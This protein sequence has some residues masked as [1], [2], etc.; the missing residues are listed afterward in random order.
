MSSANRAA[1]SEPAFGVRCVFGTYRAKVE[2]DLIVRQQYAFPILFRCRSGAS[3]RP[4]AADNCRVWSGDRRGAAQHVPHRR[5]DEG[6]DRRGIPC[7]GLRYRKGHA[8]RRSTTAIFRRFIRPATFRW[9]PKS[10]GRSLPPFAELVIG[11][12]KETVGAY[13]AALSGEAPIGFVAV[14]VDY[15]S[16]T[17]SA[18]QLLTGPPEL[19]LPIVPVYLDDIASY[20]CSDWT[21]E[22]LA[23]NEFN[24]EQAMRRLRRSR[25]CGPGGFSRTRNGSIGCLLATSTIIL[26]GLRAR[27]GR[28]ENTYR[29]STLA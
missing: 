24:D 23:V 14:D 9:M 6:G 19:Y 27:C 3:Q 13:L 25:C 17:K 18:L 20:A 4:V 7:G 21:G 15:Y 26:C 28:R 5:A 11:D 29:T 10:F 12:L 1:S 16:S 22:M 8:A 2:F